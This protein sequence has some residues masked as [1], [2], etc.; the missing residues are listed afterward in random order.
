M[1]KPINTALQMELITRADQQ[2]AEHLLALESTAIENL[3]LFIALTSAA[4]RQGHVCLSLKTDTSLEVLG[5][6]VD[7]EALAAASIVANQGAGGQP[8][9]LAG[10]RLYLARYYV[11]EQQ[12]I[13][14]LARLQQSRPIG[15]NLDLLKQGLAE[16]FSQPAVGIDWQRAAACLAVINSLCIISGGPGTGKTYTVARILRLLLDQQS[17][18]NTDEPM[19]I[20]LTAPTGKAAGRLTESILA[21]D[22]TL[23]EEIPQAQTLHRLLKMRPG[24]VMP[25]FNRANPLS[26]DVLIVDEVSMVDLPMMARILAA[27]PQHARLILLGDRY[28]LGSIEA[29]QVMADLCGTGGREYSQQLVDELTP[30]CGDSLPVAQ[31]QL[32]NMSSH[33]ITLQHSRRFDA[34]KGIGRLAAAI[35]A[36]DSEQVLSTLEQADDQYD[37]QLD[38]QLRWQGSNE[39]SLDALLLEQVLP[40]FKQVQQST[41]PAEALALLSNL[42]VLCAVHEGPQGV[43]AINR[44][45]EKHL[46]TAERQ[47]YH[48]KPLM[49]TVNHYEQQ[50]FNGDIGLVLRAEDGE[51]RVFFLTVNGS[52]RSIAPSRLP[53]HETVYAMTIHK[54]QGSEF[55]QVIL[56]LPQIDSP[57]VSRELLYTGITRAQEKVIVCAGETALIKAV[58]KQAG[59]DSGLFL[60]LW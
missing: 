51:L 29:G 25:Y 57:V 42:R 20:A 45:L 7:L 54:S 12:I 28:Q 35:N 4:L 1:P 18:A 31:T 26:I 53:A 13:A 8:L 48:G 9:V 33:V 23:L 41:N 55:K 32:T 56:V 24:R 17:N 40:L 43:K 2:L 38:G 37:G 10:S 58:N 19:R 27:L 50:L 3:D 59:H 5:V 47:L 52:V 11:W 46:G 60:A 22:A 49:I 16:Q 21:A 36:G 14:D 34:N 15:L 30:I 39:T 6:S 44:K